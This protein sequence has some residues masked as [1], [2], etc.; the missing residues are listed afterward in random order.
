[1]SS[2]F[3]IKNSEA[4]WYRF[5]FTDALGVAIDVST[6]TFE[7]GIKKNINDTT[8]K[9]QKLDATFNKA[10]AATGSVM[11]NITTAESAAAIL[12]AG[13]YVAE[14]KYIVIAGTDVAKSVNIDFTVEKAVTV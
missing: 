2:D 7:F 10:S 12:P 11:V 5:N 8:F 4:R 3:S 9:I 6:W 1:M 14:L 13:D